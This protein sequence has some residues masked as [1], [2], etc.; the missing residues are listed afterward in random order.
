[1]EKLW[2]ECTD[3]ERADVTAIELKQY[4]LRELYHTGMIS[5]RQYRYNLTRLLKK[6]DEV[7]KKY[8]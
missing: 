3:E 2:E 6:L 8:E 5:R 7:E 4:R 1:M